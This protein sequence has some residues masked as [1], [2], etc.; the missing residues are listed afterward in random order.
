VSQL[1]G[2]LVDAYIQYLKAIFNP[3]LIL[4]GVIFMSLI[5][6]VLWLVKKL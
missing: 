6:F 1:F 3:Y 4:L 5:F 2:R